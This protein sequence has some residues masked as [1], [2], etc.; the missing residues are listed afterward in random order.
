MCSGLSIPNNGACWV[1]DG[2]EDR[3]KV[4][5]YKEPVTLH[6]WLE[7]EWGQHKCYALC[8]TVVSTPSFWFVTIIGLNVEFLC[9]LNISRHLRFKASLVQFTTTS[10]LPKPEVVQQAIIV[11][12]S[13][14]VS[15]TEYYPELPNPRTSNI[16]NES[17]HVSSR[18]QAFLSFIGFRFSYK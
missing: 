9:S 1:L 16:C 11:S 17:E 6:H 8:I 3:T 12:Y 15:Q 18:C 5:A 13:T 14:E 10:S 2:S 7:T 4:C